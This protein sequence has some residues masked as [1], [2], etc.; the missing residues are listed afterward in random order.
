[1]TSQEQG[2]FLDHLERQIEARPAAAAARFGDAEM[3]YLELDRASSALAA[4]LVEAGV[5]VDSLV[6]VLVGRSLWLP[7]AILGILRAGGAYVAIDRRWPAARLREVFAQVRADVAV[8]DAEHAALVPSGSRTV[9]VEDRRPHRAA[10]P[11]RP[12]AGDAAYVMF[13]SGSTG[14]P[15]GIVVE[16]GALAAFLDWARRYFELD[17]DSR[18]IQFSRLTFDASVWELFGALSAGGTLVLVP[19]EV[20]ESP[21]LL[22]EALGR[23]RITHCDIVPSV[24]ALLEPGRAP[25]L[26][27]CM[28]GGERIV[29]EL[30]DRWAAPGRTFVN[31]YGPAEATVVS[32]ASRPR[33]G[34]APV[35]IGEPIDGVGVHLL[36]EALSPVPPGATGEVFLTGATL[37]RGY[38]GMPRETA[39]RFLPDPFSGR[40][41]AR[42]YRTGDLARRGEDG[43]FFFVGR[44]DNQVK[45]AG[46]R[47]EPEEAEAALLAI[48]E[49]VD[50]AVVVF[51][52]DDRPRLA[53][54]FV[55]DIA[56]EVV[57]RECQARLPAHVVPGHIEA[58]AELPLG[59]T[60]KIDRRALADLA[61]SGSG[62]AT[63]GEGGGEHVFLRAV[64]QVLGSSPPG[65]R[66]FVDAG[67][68]SLD[69]MRLISRLPPDVGRR[70]TVRG[71]L[72]AGSLDEIVASL[73][74]AT[75]GGAGL[76]AIEPGAVEPWPLS[77]SQLGLLLAH[78]LDPDRPTYNV[79]V[80]LR[81]D[82]PL[83]RQALAEAVRR[84]TSRQQ[85]LSRRVALDQLAAV[86]GL[87]AAAAVEL[88]QVAAAD[89]ASA[90]A[91]LRAEAQSPFDLEEEQPAR[92]LLATVAAESHLLLISAHHL[93]VDGWSVSVLLENLAQHYADVLEGTDL[94]PLPQLSF[95]DY[96]VWDSRLLGA[97]GT[98]ADIEAWQRRL[99]PYPRRLRI[100]P[101]EPPDD[102]RVPPGTREGVELGLPPEVVRA[103]QALAAAAKVS[104]FMVLLAAFSRVV[105]S[106][107]GL[108]R[109]LVGCPMSTRFDWR[110]EEGGGQPHQPPADPDRARRRSGI[111]RRPAARE[112]V[113]PRVLSP[114]PRPP[115]RDRQRHG[116]ARHRA[117]APAHPGRLPDRGPAP[118]PH[119]RRPDRRSRRNPPHLDR[120][121][122]RV[123][124]GSIPRR[125]GGRNR[126]RRLDLLP[127]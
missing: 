93:A 8:V 95:G 120:A 46:Q 26:R 119:L 43:A 90:E 27:Q 97:E 124:P 113:R 58:L 80:L 11:R 28:S 59:P 10:P 71:I 21:P 99:D 118:P 19:E 29:G 127:P 100:A 82:G 53:A 122:P 125:P 5:G 62:D 73:D 22:S 48:P 111:H 12:A 109:F 50:G 54:F 68:D 31:G 34:T 56:V 66:S 14:T 98:A 64:A 23:Y 41:G 24:L 89:R 57:V 112:R 44:R 55:G 36:D 49:V 63:A 94:V 110:L 76:P 126:F 72:Q 60:G 51:A 69:A 1:M 106:R 16:H 85:T 30:V 101:D 88:R 45:I 103:V 78:G 3:S 6:P 52:R 20:A 15:K 75:D 96:A 83:E 116:P 4:E 107:S 108:D 92:F 121:R 105:G 115:R 86:K 2:L 61:G 81:L 9:L 70:L 13:T 38:V 114:P 37:A 7:V 87:G 40:P 35:P 39:E 33:A 74:A 42:M 32:V 102:R 91:M 17:P 104:P 18:V 67:G 123:P 47:V 65:G 79:S 117:L 84:L 77:Q 25:D